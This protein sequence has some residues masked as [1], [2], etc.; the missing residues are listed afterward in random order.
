MRLRL[1]PSIYFLCFSVPYSFAFSIPSVPSFAAA[2]HL[3]HNQ[4]PLREAF[5]GWIDREERISL[6]RLLANVKPGG[7]N[8]QGNKDVVDGTVIAS[9]SKEAPDYWYQWVRDAAITTNT[10]VDLYADSPSSQLSSSLQN[11]LTAYARLQA[12]LQRTPNPS[13]TFNDLQGLG[14]PKFYVNG[15]AFTDSWGRPQRDGPALRAITLMRYLRAYNASHP[16]LWSSASPGPESFYSMLYTAEFPARSIIKADLEYVSHFWNHTSF[17]LWEEVDGMHFFTAMIQLRALREGTHVARAFGDEGAARWYSEQAGYLERFVRRFWNKDKGRL[18]ATLWSR[19]SGLDCAVLLG[20]LHG[21]PAAGEQE[22]PVFPPWADEVLDSLMGLARDMG[23]RFPINTLAPRGDGDSGNRL[24]GVGIGRYPEDVYD[25]YGTSV[26]HPWF[27]C[28][29]SAAEIL[30]RT[31]SHLS[32]TGSLTT[33]PLNVDFYAALLPP[34]SSPDLFVNTTYAAAEEPFKTVV[35]RLRHVGDEFLE[36]VKTHVDSEGSM[37]EQFDR[38]TGFLR[39]ATDL[40]WSYGAFL[41]A[42]KARNKAAGWL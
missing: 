12:D 20:S 5:D 26:G 14:E 15:S 9:P 21:L 41:Q 29:S 34:S 23:K 40:T 25:G 28:T 22:E 36:V 17:D 11:I 27:L 38:E 33:T 2:K 19:R 30:Y 10:L 24:E 1:F 35:E 31:A 18:V 42:V 7:A 37:S 39:G 16:T 13:G 3:P 8:V 4:E 32:A 6:D